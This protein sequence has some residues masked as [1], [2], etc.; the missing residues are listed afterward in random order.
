MHKYYL[1]RQPYKDFLIIK[2]DEI[3]LFDHHKNIIL[4]KLSLLKISL[5][6]HL[7]VSFV[8]R[9]GIA[10]I[11]AGDLSEEKN[12]IDCVIA[13][14]YGFC[15][16]DFLWGEKELQR[17]SSIN[18]Y[19]ALLTTGEFS[20]FD[21][22]EEEA[23]LYTDFFGLSNL[24]WAK[25]DQLIGKL[26]IA[27]NRY[28]FLLRFL[29]C[30]EVPLKID[31]TVASTL[32]LFQLSFFQQQ[33]SNLMPVS[34]VNLLGLDEFIY[35]SAD[36]F[37]IRKKRAL[38]GIL[39]GQSSSSRS[40]FYELIE[41][42][43]NDVKS[44]IKAV[45][46]HAQFKKVIVNLTGGRDSRCILAASLATIPRE[47]FTVH[48]IDIG[49][50]LPI[51]TTIAD[52]YDL[53]YYNDTSI[54]FS[55]RSAEQELEAK[56]SYFGALYIG[57]NPEGRAFINTSKTSKVKL[58][59]GGGE[60]YKTNY[61]NIYF[62]DQP[63]SGSVKHF[64]SQFM[65]ESGILKK[66]CVK[67]TTDL[68]EEVLTSMIGDTIQEKLETH[69]LFYRNR[70]HFG[71]SSL[72]WDSETGTCQP[73]MS[74]NLFSASWKLSIK[75]R[76][77]STIHNEVINRLYADLNSFPYEKDI[78][79]NPDMYSALAGDRSRWEKA[80]DDLKSGNKEYMSHLSSFNNEFNQLLFHQAKNAISKLSD[81]CPTITE[82]LTD[83]SF[84]LVNEGLKLDL[85]SK[86]FRFSKILCYK[87]VTLAAY[88]Q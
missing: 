84:D 29:N 50:D 59:G 3:S 48:T 7:V 13:S 8:E 6:C 44:N 25:V 49:Q 83:Y 53:A 33:F 56:L 76:A 68:L 41:Q 45:A 21:L 74:R 19:D 5:Q 42:G 70:F 66:S 88:I 82:G 36:A 24:V 34:G 87:L 79:N 61:Y 28:D 18:L 27:S 38:Y 46:N 40:E 80:H 69:Y 52:K 9:L 22:R 37:E 39:G 11:E 54:N 23:Y 51:A 77:S 4:Q 71:M 81:H 12:N 35:I 2:F 16:Q 47:L 72:N 26:F 58:I 10:I 32:L 62:S 60:L 64:I 75:D 31:P 30:I 15:Q 73:F 14:G 20:I 85:N 1:S 43:I 86:K 65:T 57:S 78:I 63:K 17:L 67:N 55:P